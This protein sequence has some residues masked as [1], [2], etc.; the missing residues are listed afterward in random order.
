MAL[1]LLIPRL[2]WNIVSTSGTTVLGNP[3]ISSIA[4]T[5]G[6]SVGAYVT[7]SGIPV[8]SYVLSKTP[9]TL[10]LSSNATASATVAIE[11]KER[12]DFQYPPVADSEDQY[13]VKNVISVSLDGTLQDQT[14]FVEITRDLMFDFITHTERDT[15]LRNFFLGWAYNGSEFRYYL[16]KADAL[17][18]TYSLNPGSFK[19]PTKRR[20]KKHPYFL[21]QFT[22]KFRR[23]LDNN[24]ID[25]LL[26]E[27]SDPLLTEDGHSISI[28]LD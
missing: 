4:D 22:L 13:D 9:S 1:D 10:V 7:G 24:D 23:V 20:V 19:F 12:F 25:V 15:L 17:Y 14:N 26:T 28:G 3:T 6:I 8:G 2:E 16:D 27:S 5:S 21:Y 11:A 18:S